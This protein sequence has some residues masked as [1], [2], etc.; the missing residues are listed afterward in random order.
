[1]TRQEVFVVL[2]GHGSASIGGVE[3]QLTAGSVVVVPADTDFAIEAA[4]DAEAL[5][6]LCCLPVGG[7][8]VIGEAAPF[9]PPWAC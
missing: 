7:Q 1:L 4:A 9:V 5:V 6:A 3:H 2:D 8:A